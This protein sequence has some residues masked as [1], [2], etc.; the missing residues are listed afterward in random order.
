MSNKENIEVVETA[1]TSEA[2]KTPA[3][4]APTKKVLP[5]SP[6][7]VK[8]TSSVASNQPKDEKKMTF[9]EIMSRR[10]W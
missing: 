5:S 3:K 9:E 6:S 8:N 4:K 7:S 2:K 1:E 10:N